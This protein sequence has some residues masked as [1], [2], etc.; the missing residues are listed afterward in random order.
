M[1]R[2]RT[3]DDQDPTPDVQALFDADRARDGVIL[4]STRVAAW[5]PG[6]SAAAKA[7]GKAIAA[8]GCIDA[9]LRS[10]IKVRIASL[11]GCEF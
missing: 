9:A 5:R 1:P 6:I 8:S 3:I 11:I 4:N 2:I 7:L 10:L